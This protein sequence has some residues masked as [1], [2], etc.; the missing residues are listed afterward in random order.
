MAVYCEYFETM[1]SVVTR[2]VC[3]SYLTF[4]T[5]MYC[6]YTYHY[7]IEAERRIYASVNLQSLFQIMACR[8]VGAKPL[9]ETMLE[10]C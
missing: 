5:R 8:L 7:L 3:V 6:V 10:Y 9:S 1:F 2:I 4:Y